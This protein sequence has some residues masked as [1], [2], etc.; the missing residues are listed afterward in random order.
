ML[1]APHTTRLRNF[2]R[3]N[4]AKRAENDLTGDARYPMPT[5]KTQQPDLPSVFGPEW[6]RRAYGL[7]AQR[8]V[9]SESGGFKV[10]WSRNVGARAFTVGDATTPCSR[11]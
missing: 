2:A 6:I 9:R 3:A 1:L 8:K 4:G 10:Y 11:A 5:K 7:T